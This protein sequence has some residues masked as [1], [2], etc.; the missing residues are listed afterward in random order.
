MIKRFYISILV[1]FV[2]ITFIGESAFSQ[3]ISTESSKTVNAYFM[4]H[5]Q[6]WEMKSNENTES[7]NQFSMPLFVNLRPTDNLRL[8]FVDAFSTAS[9]DKGDGEKTSLAGISDAKV[10]AS[11]SMFGN[12][13]LVSLGANLPTGKEKLNKDEIDVANILYNEILGFRVN[14]LGSGLDVNAGIAYATNF[15]TW[16]AS[17]ASSYLKK[18][19]YENVEDSNSKYK[20]G[21]EISVI[22]AIDMVTD[23]AMLNGNLAYIHYGNDQFDEESQFKE[24]DE[25][26]IKATAIYRLNPL[27]VALSVADIIRMKNKILDENNELVAEDSNSHGNRLDANI[28]FQYLINRNLSITPSTGIT[29]VADNGYGENGSFIWNLGGSIQYSLNKNANFNI[30]IKSLM[31]NM[32][33]GDVDLSGFEI[34][35]VLIAKF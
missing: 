29:F 18:G 35:T 3:V 11:Y 34:G 28:L 10:K 12:K 19:S 16:G 7:I 14:K 32:K 1:L 5:F 9:L 17:I 21:D 13:F 25:I 15:G 27:I 6:N 2:C 31:G 4:P 8:W 30:S 24:G 20:P 22:G 26:R 23:T 33:S